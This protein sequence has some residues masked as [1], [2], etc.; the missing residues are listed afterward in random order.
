MAC[1]NEVRISGRAVRDA[2]RVGNGPFRFSLAV[3]GRK[4]DGSG[5]WPTEYF[6]CICWST[7]AERIHRGDEVLVVGHLRQSRWEKD[8]Q[9][10][11]RVEIL[12][13]QLTS[14]AEAKP[15]ITPRFD[16]PEHPP[17]EQKVAAVRPVTAQD[18]IT[19]EDIPF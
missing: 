11:S 4:K 7:D 19:D 3:G 15:P 18:P 16:I 6:D 1:I 12:A 5:N 14:S 2:V 17:R 13:T 9:T 8:G 10:H